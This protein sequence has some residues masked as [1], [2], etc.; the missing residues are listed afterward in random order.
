M[1]FSWKNQ[2]NEHE[3][4]SWWCRTSSRFEAL[5]RT[6]VPF[7]VRCRVTDGVTG[8]AG[9]EQGVMEPEENDKAIL[10]LLPAAFGVVLSQ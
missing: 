10:S 3:A 2:V 4:G 1:T 6:T 8:S 7:S 5:W 9:W